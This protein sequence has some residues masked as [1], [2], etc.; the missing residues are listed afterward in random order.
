[1]TP[2]KRPNVYAKGQGSIFRVPADLNKPLVGWR[3]SLPRSPLDGD[4]RAVVRQ[5]K[6]KAL[7]EEQLTL[8]RR[9]FAKEGDIAT[10]GDTMQQW[11][12]A[13]FAEFV[14]GHL[15]PKTVAN[16]RSTLTNHIIP[17]LGRVR[18]DKLT[19]AHVRKM[20]T[21]ITSKLKDPKH[22][23]KGKL[24]SSTA[25]YAHNVLVAALTDAIRE[26]HV[27]RNV[28]ALT[29]AP[30]A[31]P[32]KLA[33]MSTASGVKVLRTVLQPPGDGTPAD[34]LGSRWAAALLIGARQGEIIGLELDRVIQITSD[35]GVTS[36]WLD[37][38]WQLQRLAWLHGC[39]TPC[40][41]KRG[42][43]C[44]ARTLDAPEDW[45]HRWIEGGLWFSRPKS[46]AGIRLIPLVEPLRTWIEQRI[47][48]AATEP[49]P[50]NLVWTADPKK[51]RHGRPLPLDGSPIDPSR[52]NAAW[53]EVLERAGVP[54]TH[55]HAARHTTASLLQKARV[56]MSVRMRI[57]GHGSSAMV[58]HYTD[59]DEAQMES[60]MLAFSSLLAL[61]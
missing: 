41:K 56:P 42:T 53:H 51:D 29:S 20:R 7:A 57:L 38:S 27:T 46:D 58:E 6:T 11:L 39:A 21:D 35:S 3:A 60:G 16:Y 8:M 24:S 50:H 40:G 17:S 52:D 49:N 26:G 18:L 44:P 4:R 30:K 59:V 45:E 55:L 48:V 34:R 33:I 15:R 32:A 54:Q 12:E 10:S 43:D 2:P 14:K 19:P 61:D 22:P 47:E 1:M 31:A 23:E 9:Q 28:A 5:R 37:L 13:W 25:L 36:P